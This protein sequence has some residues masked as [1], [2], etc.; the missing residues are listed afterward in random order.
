MSSAFVAWLAQ[1]PQ[2]ATASCATLFGMLIALHAVD[3]A[4]ARSHKQSATATVA[5]TP[6]HSTSTSNN[7]SASAFTSFRRQYLTVYFLVMFA[8]WLQGTHM[9]SLY[10]VQSSMHVL[11][12]TYSLVSCHCE[13]T[14]SRSLRVTELRRERER[15]LPRRLPLVCALW[16]LCWPDRRPLRPSQRVS[17]LLRTRG[18]HTHA[19]SRR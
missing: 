12:R 11:T 1:W 6:C 2:W 13:R 7:D 17:G 15:A 3:R 4:I 9:Y 14:D 16:E 18:A 19:C 5:A 8:D 10:Q